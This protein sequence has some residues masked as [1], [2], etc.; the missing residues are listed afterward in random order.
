MIRIFTVTAPLGGVDPAAAV[1][2]LDKAT[3]M[4]TR[5]YPALRG[6]QAHAADGVLTL[7]IRVSSRDQWACTAAARKIGTNMLLRLKIPADQ[8]K[9]ELVRTVPSARSLTG[10]AG[11]SATRAEAVS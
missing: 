5:L 7:T 10:A 1:S 11:R 6:A 9:L 3:D 2:T 8:G 4:L